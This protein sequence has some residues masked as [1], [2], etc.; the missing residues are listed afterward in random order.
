MAWGL[1]PSQPM[2]DEQRRAM[3]WR[4]SHGGGR[5]APRSPELQAQYDRMKAAGIKIYGPE[6]EVSWWD[7]TKA[8]LSGA[9][10]GTKEGATLVADDYT[11][12]LIDPLHEAA[13]NLKSKGGWDIAFADK[14]GGLSS[15]LMHAAIGGAALNALG[16]A[17]GATKF[18]ATVA[19]RLLIPG[20]AIGGF[21][22]QS[23]IEDYRA[24]NPTMSPTKHALLARAAQASGYIGSIALLSTALA[25][26]KM[27]GRFIKPHTILNLKKAVAQKPLHSLSSYI[28]VGLRKSDRIIGA[29]GRAIKDGASKTSTAIL[30][31]SVGGALNTG[32][33]KLLAGWSK[34]ADFT[35]STFK[36]LAA[37]P[38]ALKSLKSARAMTAESG[39]L[40]RKATGLLLRT[41]NT[42]RPNIHIQ[43]IASKM[44]LKSAELGQRAGILRAEAL[45]SLKKAA[46][47]ALGIAGIETR[48]ALKIRAKAE[49]IK[50]DIR[51]G[52]ET[53]A[54]MDEERGPIG[55]AFAA[56]V[57]SSG[58]PVER[59]F[60]PGL[61]A[62]H[63]RLAAYKAGYE[64]INRVAKEDNW[65]AARREAALLEH[66]KSMPADMQGK[67]LW[68]FAPAATTFINWKVGDLVRKAKLSTVA[69]VTRVVDGDTIIVDHLFPGQ[70]EETRGEIRFQGIDTPETVH[71]NKPIQ[72]MGPEAS[73]YTKEKLK[74]APYVRIV[75][76]SHPKAYGVDKYGRMM[77]V[78][79]TLP[80]P[81]DKLLTIPRV[82]KYIPAMDLNEKLLRLGLA[83]TAYRGLSGRTDR[84]AAYDA[85]RE[86]AV[87]DAARGKTPS[88][89]DAVGRELLPQQQYALLSEKTYEQKA[90]E[91]FKELTG[92]DRPP[93]RW[94]KFA[95]PAGV[96]LM[97]SGNTGLWGQMPISGNTLVT[98]YNAA[99][100]VSGAFEYN[101]RAR[102]AI[103]YNLSTPTYLSDYRRD[104][105]RRGYNLPP[106]SRPRYTAADRRLIETFRS[107]W[108]PPQ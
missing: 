7:K 100:A 10:E 29:L 90:D 49:S 77:G 59:L 108:A 37:V 98:L 12:G 15:G 1:R 95:Q 16:R 5:A 52:R 107:S 99:L 89:F 32:A 2:S 67:A 36:E 20:L 22:G 18:S 96:G 84:D 6:N 83:D 81:F 76:D 19:G 23:A 9:W 58:N 65:P 66:S 40:S 25:Y 103:P 17:Y 87:R 39:M 75:A 31:K 46:Y 28:R 35:G 64:E 106:P 53:P 70:P 94:G 61:A 74:G 34:L 62:H 55:T 63:A 45:G 33:N 93:E 104:M 8:F 88:I 57:G 78:V 48:D 86:A 41:F 92:R 60:R 11:L 91:R 54:P 105:E 26:G 47:V 72:Y 80:R 97:A 43:D 51:A 21:A 102:R 71:P 30:G 85:A 38:R 27:L 13:E 69:K 4:M 50:E 101:E 68:Q 44:M 82:G 24:A 79:E 3:F 56:T 73:K 42:A 14:L